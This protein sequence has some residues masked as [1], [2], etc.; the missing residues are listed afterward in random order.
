LGNDVD[1]E[2]EQESGSISAKAEVEADTNAPPPIQP[3]PLVSATGPISELA[4]EMAASILDS[5]VVSVP[6][7]ARVDTASG[8]YQALESKHRVLESAV[9]SPVSNPVQENSN[10]EI[11]ASNVL[12]FVAE[13]RAAARRTG[14]AS[15]RAESESILRLPSS[16]Q[17]PTPIADTT[18]TSAAATTAATA[19]ESPDRL[20][21]IVLE[22]HSSASGSSPD[23]AVKDARAELFLKTE[24]LLHFRL[25][26]AATGLVLCVGLSSFGKSDL[27]F[28]QL[29]LLTMAVL[30]YSTAA[31]VLLE[32]KFIVTRHV[33]IYLNAILVASDILVVTGMVHE[34]KG[35][36]SDLYVLYLL[37]ILLSSFTFGRRGITASSF[38][39]SVSYVCLLLWENASLLPYIMVKHQTAGLAAAYSQQL[40]RRIL[41]RSALLVS[42]TFIWGRFCEYMSGLERLSTNRL[43]EQL[44]ANNDLINEMKAQAAREVLINSINSELRSSLDLNKIFE[45]AVDELGKAL[46]ASCSAIVCPS[47]YPSEPPI[48]CESIIPSS[49]SG[50]EED[51]IDENLF[52]GPKICEF[53]LRHKSTYEKDDAVSK[54]YL[55]HNPADSQLF[56]PIKEELQRLNF[57]SLIIKPMIYRDESKGV[58]LIA[59]LD[60]QR[61]WTA[62]DLQLVNSVAGQVSVAIEHAELVDQL[63]RKNADLVSKNLNLDAK[64]LELRAMQS[65]LIHQEKM[66]SLGRLVAGIAHELNNPINFVHGN[67]PYLRNYFDDLKKIIDS[68][69]NLPDQHRNPINELKKS[70][71]YNFL[72]TD[73]DNILADL[74]D[75]TERIRHI[76]RNLKSFS[77]LDE[78]ELKDASIQEG[79]E[80]SLKI[81][82]QYYG[83]DKIP[84]KI[85]FAEL[86][87]ILCYPGQLNQVWMNLFSNAAQAVESRS[88]PRVS[89][90]TEIENGKVLISVSDNGTGI[91][92]EVQSKIFEPFYTTKPVG[93]GTGLGLS[94]C[95][96]I[97]ERHGGQI[98]CESAPGQGTT[99]RV[100]L[101][102]YSHPSELRSMEKGRDINNG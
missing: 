7:F 28:I 3:E 12:E 43:R 25:A 49:L 39:V 102:I 36:D 44:I 17:T 23:S 77:R 66:A 32:R 61:V 33:M 90:R 91:N 8:A 76:I 73:L 5:S 98:W 83:R 37:P 78:A 4:A 30:A 55:Y 19:T 31:I 9:A 100:R 81:L 35:L 51:K 84:V 88:E 54:I 71:K 74:D 47:A 89:V 48:V 94:I 60:H 13:R 6:V 16:I 80:S 62:S 57:G 63:S 52:F 96:S 69:D 14:D 67:L 97:I 86:P 101:P 26:F 40:W 34:T 11:A 18:L 10:L 22:R 93:Q 95:H 65:Q 42:V 38:F 1:T 64:N 72:V 68:L 99:F 75:G 59:D 87:P 56:E 46:H 45:T 50:V 27:D 70:V 92:P 41:A 2:L 15:S 21:S 20:S 24:K 53:V 82:S 85:E 79:I 58:L 29:A